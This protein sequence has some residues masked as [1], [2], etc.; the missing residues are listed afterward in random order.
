MEDLSSPVS[1]ASSTATAPS[2]ASKV[3]YTTAGTPYN[4][5]TSQPLQPPARRGRS[6]KWPASLPAAGLSLLPKSV[7]A[8]LPIKTTRSSSLQ[9][10]SPQTQYDG[11]S[12]PLTDTDHGSVN[13]SAQVPRLGSSAT[14]SPLASLFSET[15]QDT[16]TDADP[17]DE[18]DD[19]RELGMDLLLNMTVKSLHNLASYPNPNQKKAQKAL[20]RGIKPALGLKSATR[21]E[22]PC[23]P[24]SGS[25]SLPKALKY[26]TDSPGISHR[27]RREARCG[28][29][30]S[31]I[32]PVTLDGFDHAVGSNSTLVADNL[33]SATRVLSSGAPLPLT[34][35][36]P[37]QRQY[38][39]STF[40]STFKALHT[41]TPTQDSIQEEDGDVLAIN[42]QTL[43]QA[44][45]GAMSLEQDSPSLKTMP[46]LVSNS[47][48]P[49][50]TTAADY[51]E[52]SDIG[53]ESARTSEI[54]SYLVQEPLQPSNVT[55][56]WAWG[57]TVASDCR[58]SSRKHTQHSY[59]QG[60]RTRTVRD[61]ETRSEE[62]NR[63]WYAGADFLLASSDE[64]A[65]QV[66]PP[67]VKGAFGAIGDGRPSKKGDYH[68]PMS[69]NHANRMAVAEHA[70]P[71]FNMAHANVQQ[72][73][74]EEWQKN[75]TGHAS[76]VQATR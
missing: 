67:I 73:V 35:G 12:S 56:P 36:P 23:Y 57:S 76:S 59:A 39:P 53:N 40:E 46:P 72:F 4:P 51:T 31:S 54:L 33:G 2:S 27:P 5:S 49:T 28:D 19:D 29:R 1:I 69:I 41:S 14:P 10:Y 47:P 52:D 20:L 66:Q 18:S 68:Y 6:L 22:E 44:G 37:G 26:N 61:I 58:A 38:R 24:L 43:R 55:P 48:L 64:I 3:T 11:P 13:M 70:R 21:S 42:R 50:S 75:N 30:S 25:P 9:R 15:E 60:P 7:L 45:I 32:H 65:I 74:G 34:A 17:S 16:F 63:A 8:T 62:V 71:L